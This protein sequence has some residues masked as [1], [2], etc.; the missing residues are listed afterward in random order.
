MHP[1]PRTDAD[2]LLHCSAA[3][4]N[5]EVDGAQIVKNEEWE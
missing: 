5:D 1:E 3:V 2:D 4:G